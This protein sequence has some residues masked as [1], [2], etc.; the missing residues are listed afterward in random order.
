MLHKQK[1]LGLEVSLYGP[2]AWKFPKESGED[3]FGDLLR[4]G[5]EGGW[6][7]LAR[8]FTQWPYSSVQ[9]DAHAGILQILNSSENSDPTETQRRIH[10]YILQCRAKHVHY[11]GTSSAKMRRIDWIGIFPEGEVDIRT[12]EEAHTLLSHIR[13]THGRKAK[14][15]GKRDDLPYHI[16]VIF[17][18]AAVNTMQGITSAERISRDVLWYTF[19]KAQNE[20]GSL[21][22]GGISLFDDKDLEQELLTCAS[23]NG[24]WAHPLFD[25][26]G[27]VLFPR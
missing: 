2:R 26:K 8:G 19:D 23:S 9:A 5:A 14:I 21:L 12:R 7:R 4:R 22:L 24:A 15:E 13:D 1:F 25:A 16:G 17:D 3:T 20:N 18:P 6:G 27:N 11:S 10:E